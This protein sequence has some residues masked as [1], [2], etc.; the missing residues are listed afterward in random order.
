MFRSPLVLP[1]TLIFAGVLA[2]MAT[3]GVLPPTVLRFWPIVFVILGLVG[4]VSLSSEELTGQTTTTSKKTSSSSSASKSAPA[5]KS[6]AKTASKST[7]SKSKSSS[8]K[9]TTSKKK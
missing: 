6:A 8:K 4:L 2:F 9:K 1:L 5:K 3:T 7:S